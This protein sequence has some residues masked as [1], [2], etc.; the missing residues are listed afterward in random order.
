[1]VLP[2]VPEVVWETVRSNGSKTYVVVTA[3]PPLP[4]RV[5]TVR[6]KPS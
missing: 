6:S 4:D 2:A 5:F 3:D 1:M